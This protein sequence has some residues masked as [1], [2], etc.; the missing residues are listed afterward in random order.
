[1]SILASELIYNIKNLKGGGIQS[2]DEN[3]SDRQLYFIINY[4]RAKLVRQE[5]QRHGVIPPEMVQDLG[6][7]NLITADP[8]ECDCP[9]EACVLRT[10]LKLPNTL[11][12]ADRHHGLT[13]AGMYGCMS[14]QETTWQAGPWT[15]FSKYT[16]KNTKWLLKGNY[17][18]ILN[19][20]DPMLSYMNIQGL[21]E[22]PLE[23]TK[24]RT[25]DCDNGEDCIEGFDFPY[26]IS[27]HMV[28]TLTKMIMENEI[29]WSSLIPEDTAN[30]SLDSN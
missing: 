27:S 8:H 13:F 4:Y 12:L 24:F 30:D 29:R 11:L 1:M 22:D 3:L 15:M 23:A 9:A 21:F 16:G 5:V 17:M 19:P 7:V 6:K 14:W 26:P 28:D 10:E 18:Y 25:C 20:S 2:D